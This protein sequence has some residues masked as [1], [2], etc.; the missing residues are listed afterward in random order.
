MADGDKFFRV[1]LIG[2][3]LLKSCGNVVSVEYNI[4]S[5]TSDGGTGVGT[6]VV[7]VFNNCYTTIYNCL[8]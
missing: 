1:I 4:F 2:L 6:T 8:N 5:I 3:S 7:I